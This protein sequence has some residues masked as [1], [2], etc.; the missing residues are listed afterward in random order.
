MYNKK[1]DNSSIAAINPI[2]FTTD[3]KFK[4]QSKTKKK[5]KSFDLILNEELKTQTNISA[6]VKPENLDLLN[7]LYLTHNLTKVQRQF[8]NR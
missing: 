7:N 4:E 8:L 3:P 5:D 6:A 2:A 1:K